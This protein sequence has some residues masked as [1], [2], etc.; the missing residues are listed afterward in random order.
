MITQNEIDNANV[1]F[2]K[3]MNIVEELEKTYPPAINESIAISTSMKAKAT[4]IIMELAR[5]KGDLEP[6]IKHGYIL[7]K[8]R[9]L[10]AD[11][12]AMAHDHKIVFGKAPFIDKFEMKTEVQSPELLTPNM[13][14]RTNE[15]VFRNIRLDHKDN[16]LKKVI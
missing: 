11:Y 5:W 13:I 8:I 7:E 2:N 12:N 6:L 14:K 4:G 10:V 16:K 9:G 1:K 15:S 3:L